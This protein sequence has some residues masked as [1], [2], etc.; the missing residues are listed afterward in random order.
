MPYTRRYPRKRRSY[1]SRPKKGRPSYKKKR[2]ARKRTAAVRGRMGVPRTLQVE[3]KRQ[4]NVVKRFQ[5][6][7][8][9]TLRPGF[10]NEMEST[11]VFQIIKA[12]SPLS[13]NAQFSDGWDNSID[14]YPDGHPNTKPAEM[15]WN[16]QDA[17]AATGYGPLA[18]HRHMP[19]ILDDGTKRYQHF[20]VLGAKLTVTITPTG[21]NA[22]IS[23]GVWEA[24]TEPICDSPVQLFMYK[25]GT[26]GDIAKENAADTIA[27]K[28]FVVR[29]NFLPGS[30]TTQSVTMSMSYS[31]KK[32]EGVRG[33]V[34]GHDHLRGRL[35]RWNDLSST[36]IDQGADPSEKS[37][38]V[39]GIC[40][41]RGAAR[42]KVVGNNK[43]SYGAILPEFLVQQKIEYIVALTEPSRVQTGNDQNEAWGGMMVDSGAGADK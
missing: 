8:T 2:Y 25:T 31:A 12:N 14:I 35:P 29:K 36:F 37:F 18:T 22:N 38:F 27:Q 9:Y 3:S 20:T 15:I 43:N 40:D 1:K 7:Q 11:T 26:S 39:W 19:G 13:F 32:Y 33:S 30:D 17:T 34:M 24:D 23:G 28:P 16:P 4:R 42:P 10:A 6:L 41:A 21:N 5:A